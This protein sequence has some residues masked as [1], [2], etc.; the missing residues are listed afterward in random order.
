MLL[1]RTS[2]VWSVSSVPNT[3]WGTPQRAGE[4]L[5]EVSL[6]AV[7]PPRGRIY[8]ALVKGEP[9]FPDPSELARSREAQDQ[10]WR[11]IAAMVGIG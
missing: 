2:S 11:E 7:T 10:L 5:A 8:V 4:A 1:M 3:S 9:T 6:G